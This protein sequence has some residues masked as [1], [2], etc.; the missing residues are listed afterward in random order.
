MMSFF[1]SGPTRILAYAV[2]CAALS[3]VATVP[4]FAQRGDAPMAP[5][6]PAREQFTGI[7]AATPEGSVYP[8]ADVQVVRM[9]HAGELRAPA[10]LDVPEYGRALEVMHWDWLSAIG[11]PVTLLVENRAVPWVAL[12]PGAAVVATGTDRIDLVAGALEWQGT[13]PSLLRRVVSAGTLRVTGRG[14]ALVARTED[15]VT[16]AVAAGSFEILDGGSLVAVLGAGQHRRFPGADDRG[17]ETRFREAFG[18]LSSAH[19]QA[20]VALLGE[21]FLDGASLERLWETVLPAVVIYE[22]AAAERAPWVM[23]PDVRRNQ[24][25]EALRLLAAYRFQVPPDRGM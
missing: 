9:G 16:V 4:V 2:V 13:D 23:L 10:A 20:L 19:D 8:G 3:L 21:N 1:G 5:A 18:A 22:R 6:V 14:T 7:V 15:A 12:Q 24:I 17:L 11:G 25:A